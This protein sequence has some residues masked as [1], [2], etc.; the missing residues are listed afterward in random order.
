LAVALTR[1]G[2]QLSAAQQRTLAILA[3]L[4]Q[5]TERER[6]VEWDR[7]LRAEVDDAGPDARVA[8]MIDLMIEL[9]RG[10]VF[11]DFDHARANA[12]LGQLTDSLQRAGVRP[13]S[14]ATVDG[15]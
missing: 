12:I 7:E 4:P 8:E 1:S 15:E 13:P 9:C 11:G 3:D 6:L 10:V 14:V 5:Y 2:V